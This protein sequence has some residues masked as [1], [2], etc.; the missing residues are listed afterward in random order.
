MEQNESKVWETAAEAIRLGVGAYLLPFAFIYNPALL[1]RG[2]VAEV[3]LAA[4]TALVGATLLAAAIRGYAFSELSWIQRLSLFAAGVCFIAPG[5]WTLVAGVTL[6]T[7]GL[8]GRFRGSPPESPL[9]T[10]W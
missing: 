3:I 6:S 1:G 5:V 8:L 2:S 10:R 4:A 7:L 9:G